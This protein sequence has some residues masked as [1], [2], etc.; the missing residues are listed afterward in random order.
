MEIS[1][2]ARLPKLLLLEKHVQLVY[3]FVDGLFLSRNIKMKGTTNI[4][5]GILRKRPSVSG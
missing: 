1:W 5:S 4:G 3:P 2:L